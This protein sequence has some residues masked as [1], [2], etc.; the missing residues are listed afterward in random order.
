[1]KRATLLLVYLLLGSCLSMGLIGFYRPVSAENFVFYDDF[2]DGSLDTTKWIED[3]AGS[4]NSYREANGE[5]EF[6]VFGHGGWGKGHSALVSR[7][8]E[9]GDWESITISGRWK[10]TDPHTAEM[11]MGIDGPAKGQHIWVH[12]VS[13]NGPKITYRYGNASKSEPR[14]IP[15]EY[16]PFKLVIYPDRFEFWES[17]KLVTTVQTECMKKAERIRLT[18]GGWDASPLISHVYFDDVRIGYTPVVASSTTNK[19]TASITG[20]AED[21]RS[22]SPAAGSKL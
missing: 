5:A 19:N 6:V 2:N 15:T 21:T 4:G 18:I 14:E 20:S 9:L 12:Y 16:V 11:V 17:G 22:S 13:W 8:I 1:M 3:V 7:W 10:F